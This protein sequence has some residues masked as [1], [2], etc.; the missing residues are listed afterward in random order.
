M[1]TCYADVNHC[2]QSL[3][4]GSVSRDD[5]ISRELQMVYSKKFLHSGFLQKDCIE[6][7]IKSFLGYPFSISKLYTSM[8]KLEYIAEIRASS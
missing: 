2:G 4:D 6:K 7:N 1:N 5:N 8:I 3:F